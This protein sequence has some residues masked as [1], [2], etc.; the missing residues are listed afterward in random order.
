[1]RA[2]SAFSMTVGSPPSR[3]AMHELVVPRSM[4]IVLPIRTS[5]WSSRKKSKREYGRSF[6]HPQGAL[7]PF[8]GTRHTLGCRGR[9]RPPRAHPHC[10]RCGRRLAACGDDDDSGAPPRAATPSPTPHSHRARARRGRGRPEGHEHEARDP[11]AHRDP[12]AQAREAGH[13]E[14]QGTGAKRGRHR[15]RATTWAR[16]SRTARSST[17]PG[18]PAPLSP[19]SSAPGKV[20]AGWDKGLVGIKKGG[21]RMLTIPPEM[22]YGAAGLPARHPAERDARVRRGRRLDQVG[23]A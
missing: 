18:T 11:E 4:P 14:G 13:R 9:C 20:I 21:R 7:T 19:C 16:T 23:R 2:P 6:R 8:A 5:P 12:A 3:T 10:C 15:D 22:G 1:M 17:R